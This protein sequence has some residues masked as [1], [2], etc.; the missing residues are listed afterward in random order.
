[1]RRNISVFAGILA[2]GFV[3]W[4]S[5]E[6]AQ[7]LPRYSARYEQNCGLC[8]VNPTGGG[9]RTLYAAQ[10]I[11]PSELAMRN[12]T[13]EQLAAIDPQL[14][15]SISIGVDLRWEDHHADLKNA[16]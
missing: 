10:Y 8:H 5:A 9:Q 4:F 6:P 15:K 3:A 7:A 12:A 1:M 2:A 13:P 16:T 14:S 11:I